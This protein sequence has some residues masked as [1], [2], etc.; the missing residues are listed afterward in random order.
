MISLKITSVKTFMSHLLL[1]DTFDHFHF[2]EGEIVTSN[3]FTIDGY[4]QKSFF[5]EQDDLEEY[6]SWSSLRDYCFRLIRGKRTPLS[7]KFIFRLSPDQIGTLIRTNN[8]DFLADQIQGCYLNIHYDGS[9]LRC[10]TGTSLKLFTLDKSVE[11]AWD[12]TTLKFFSEKEI[13]YDV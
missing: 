4:I 8:L 11:H 13:P 7:F 1:S 5:S 12:Q 2:I 3:T 9:T 10:T 6:A